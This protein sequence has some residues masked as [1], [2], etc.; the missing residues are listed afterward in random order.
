M[1]VLEDRLWACV[2]EFGGQGDQSLLLAEFSY[3]NNYH[4]SIQMAPFEALYDPCCC[5]PFGWFK[6]T[7]STP[8]SRFAG[9]CL[10]Q[11]L[12]DT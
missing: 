10:S 2:L 12:G 1:Q 8:Y 11:Y 3:N 4:T 9:E 7:M 5:T 6:S